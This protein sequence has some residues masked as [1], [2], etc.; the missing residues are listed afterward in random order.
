MCCLRG[1]LTGPARSAGGA[2]FD[3]TLMGELLG[4]A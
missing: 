1:K 2:F 3:G 4:G